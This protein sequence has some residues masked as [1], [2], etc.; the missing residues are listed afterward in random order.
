MSN[1]RKWLEET[2]PHA[3]IGDRLS[4]A[5]NISASTAAATAATFRFEHTCGER[6]CLA[7]AEFE[8]Q[9][10]DARRRKP[11][12]RR[13]SRVASA[14]C[15]RLPR[16]YYDVQKHRL[17]ALLRFETARDDL[18]ARLF[19]SPNVDAYADA[20]FTVNTDRGPK[21][22]LAP[23][24]MPLVLTSA[25]TGAAAAR[26]HLL[27]PRSLSPAFLG[28][29]EHGQ[30][31]LP[32]AV[33]LQNFA[34]GCEMFACEL[35]PA[36]V[37]SADPT[38]LFRQQRDVLYR[39][40]AAQRYRYGDTLERH[41]AQLKSQR[42]MLA[43]VQSTDEARRVRVPAALFDVPPKFVFVRRDGREMHLDALGARAVLCSFYESLARR[44]A[45]Y[46]QLVALHVQ[47]RK[48]L[49]LVGAGARLIN[50]PVTPHDLERYFNDADAPFG[51]EMA[52]FTMLRL[53]TE[54]GT[55][56]AEP[57]WRAAWRRLFD[58]RSF[59]EYFSNSAT[60]AIK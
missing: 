18:S 9:H 30:P 47:E 43:E 23:P 11:L 33:N 49:L 60:P 44:T 10:L 42:R 12:C 15:A 2:Q 19:A 27:R 57:P 46:A 6:G 28:P 26:T 40:A 25:T 22:P 21:T 34:V 31:D 48:S 7:R 52:L 20:C 5:S 35:A 45:D 1:K 41:R 38:L 32:A 58:G 54:F 29:V 8:T 39:C 3:A 14:V 51:H 17:T 16:N 36:D 50:F 37:D 53:E 4:S 59:A 24:P 56:A 13:H 55:A